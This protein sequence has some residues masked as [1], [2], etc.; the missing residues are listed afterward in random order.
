MNIEAS[1]IIVNWK[2]RDLLRA[3]LQSV[4]DQA[5]LRIDQM[6]VIVVDNNSGDGSV[7]MVQAEFPEVRLILVHG[8]LRG[9]A[10][11]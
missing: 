2:V 7:E 9:A 3:C 11:P 6:E 4:R 5:G 8:S 1:I 10:Q